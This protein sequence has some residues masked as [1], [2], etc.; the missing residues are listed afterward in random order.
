MTAD[1]CT[2]NSADPKLVFAFTELRSPYPAYINVQRLADGTAKII[3]R[4]HPSLQFQ[5]MAG[6]P[7]VDVPGQTTEIILPAAA[8]ENFIKAAAQKL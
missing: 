6:G 1:G 5:G 8:Y 7:P 3:V 4:G 2:T